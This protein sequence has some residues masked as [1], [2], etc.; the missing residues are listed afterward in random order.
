MLLHEIRNELLESL[1][2][3]VRI[4]RVLEASADYAKQDFVEFEAH[5]R[6]VRVKIV[7]LHLEICSNEKTIDCRKLKVLAINELAVADEV[8]EIDPA[9]VRKR[10]RRNQVDKNRGN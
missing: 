10:G 5:E 3:T 2:V 9:D 1:G 6:I 7:L 4:T 8:R